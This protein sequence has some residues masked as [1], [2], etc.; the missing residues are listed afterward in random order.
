MDGCALCVNHV[1][2]STSA[3]FTPLN[4]VSAADRGISVCRTG[5]EGLDDLGHLSIR[6]LLLCVGGPALT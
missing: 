4:S 1:L 6:P 3:G 5:P 2:R